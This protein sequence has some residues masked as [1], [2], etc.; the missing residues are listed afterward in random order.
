M[1]TEEK[2]RMKM[3]F[4]KF[5]K[6][7]ERDNFEGKYNLFENVDVVSYLVT[8]FKQFLMVRIGF[9]SKFVFS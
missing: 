9:F 1:L 7:R 6:K 2:K 4:L 3:I 5:K 8:R